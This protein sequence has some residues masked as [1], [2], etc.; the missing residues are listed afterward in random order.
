MMTD[1]P[2][3]SQRKCIRLNGINGK[4]LEVLP[5]PNMPSLQMVSGVQRVPK[6]PGS[7]RQGWDQK[8]QL[9]CLPLFHSSRHCST[10]FP[11]VSGGPPGTEDSEKLLREVSLCKVT[12]LGSGRARFQTQK[13]D[14]RACTWN[15]LLAQCPAC[16]G[17]CDYCSSSL[18]TVG[19]VDIGHIPPGESDQ[20]TPGLLWA[21]QA[22]IGC[23]EVLHIHPEAC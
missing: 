6:E 19:E 8:L 14:S 22:N 16:P 20:S 11:L 12:Q 17:S 18:G 4:V 15:P 5:W 23:E 9:P 2:F 7:H 21:V 10:F 13:S 1:Q 3:Y